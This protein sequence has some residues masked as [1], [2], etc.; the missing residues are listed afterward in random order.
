M[1]TPPSFDFAAP[2]ELMVGVWDGLSS[3]YTADDHF[4]GSWASR[5]VIY[6]KK[7]GEILC[8][9]QV[10]QGDPIAFDAGNDAHMAAMHQSRAGDE[11][12][13]D[14]HID[15]KRGRGQS[16]SDGRQYEGFETTPGTYLFH[17]RTPQGCFY[18]NQFFPS[19]NERRIIGPFV[20]NGTMNVLRVLSQVFTR[21]SY[22]V[23]EEYKVDDAHP[24]GA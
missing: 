3:V 6:W 22:D 16:K 19:P 11:F 14:F 12:H 20:E 2:Y 4:V 8:F 5:V 10:Q 1:P 21:I 13:V 7:P 24:H 18:N 9:R 15:G 23:P 17:I